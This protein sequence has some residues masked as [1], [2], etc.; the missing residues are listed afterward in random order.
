[1][2]PERIADME[3]HKEKVDEKLCVDF[4]WLKIK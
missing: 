2:T 1:M 3:L 4:Y